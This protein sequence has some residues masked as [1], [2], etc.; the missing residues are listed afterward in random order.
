[1]SWTFTANQTELM[2]WTFTAKCNRCLTHELDIR[3]KMQQMSN[4]WVGHALQNIADFQLMSWTFTPKC[5]RCPTGELD[6]HCEIAANCQTHEL[7][8]Q[9]MSWTFTA[10]RNTDVQLV[11]WTLLAECSRCPTHESWVGHSLQIA[12]DVQ[13]MRLDIMQCKR[14]QMSIPWVGPTP[15]QRPHWYQKPAF[16]KDN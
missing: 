5:S 16:A 1:M 4:P 6:I 15:F 8:V 11:S 9:L 7:D 2:S 12:A 10:K 14:Q 13:L 3:S